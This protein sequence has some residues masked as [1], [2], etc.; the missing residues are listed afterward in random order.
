MEPSEPG[1]LLEIADGVWTDTGPV[2]IVGMP[3]SSTMTVLR[4]KS[5]ELLLCSPVAM[6]EQRRASVEALGRVAHLYAPN[7]FHHRWLGDWASAFPAARIH[8]P[9]GL[10]K[11]RPDLRIA[12]THAT[13]PE[14][15]FEGVVE[16]LPIEGFRLRETALFYRPARTLIVTDLVQNVGEPTHPWTAIYTSLM[17]F[18]GRVALSRAIRWTGFGDRRAARRSLDAVLAHDF[19]RVVVGHGAP[20][21]SGGREALAAAYG[22]LKA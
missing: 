10:A 15:A 12:R 20:L 13:S 14:P 3:L 17:G 4:L 19:E 18:R 1:Q 11:K 6:T 9:A 7:L 22:W 16:E 8:A 21:L 5:G 2:R